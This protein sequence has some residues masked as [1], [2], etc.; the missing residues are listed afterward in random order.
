MIDEEIVIEAV[1]AFLKSGLT[2]VKR[3]DRSIRAM[4][5]ERA[6]PTSGEEFF[7]VYG[8]DLSPIN[9]PSSIVKR[10]EYSFTVA[11]TRRVNAVPDSE[12]G[13]AVLTYKDE[14]RLKPSVKK[15]AIEIVNLID[16]S[17][18]LMNNINTV[19]MAAGYTGCFVIP[20]GLVS[21]TI[22]VERVGADHFNIDGEEIPPGLVPVGLLTRLEF[23]GAQYFEN[24]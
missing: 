8:S 14:I 7:S 15:R 23:G 17:Y 22:E 3:A 16:P 1:V 20:F 12:S 2:N 24:K 11:Y 9:P 4:I 13:E 5:D 21:A 18:T 6:S 10:H 19:L